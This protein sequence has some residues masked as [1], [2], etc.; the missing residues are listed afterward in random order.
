MG[1]AVCCQHRESRRPT[2]SFE[3]SQCRRSLAH[4]LE[5]SSHRVKPSMN[6]E[7]SLAKMGRLT[8]NASRLLENGAA[9]TSFLY[10]AEKTALLSIRLQMC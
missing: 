1:F 4:G 9:N 7:A 6:R 5:E 8:G 10:A 3:L 2:Q